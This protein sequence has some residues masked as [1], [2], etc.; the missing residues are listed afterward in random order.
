MEEVWKDIIGH[1]NYQISSLGR[2]KVKSRIYINKLGVSKQ[3]KER[4][5]TPKKWGVS[6]DS[7]PYKIEG[8]MLRHF[9]EKLTEYFINSNT[10]DGEIWKDIAGYEGY[11]KVSNLGRV[12]SLP[13]ILGTK[14]IK[15]TKTL[16]TRLGTILKPIRNGDFDKDGAYRVSVILIKDGKSTN[17]LVNRLVAEAF[18]PNPNNLPE[19]NHINRDITNNTVENLEWIS[20]DANKQHALLSRESIVALYK[21]ALK[22]EVSPSDMLLKLISNY[23]S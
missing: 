14:T 7:H 16:S 6:I 8:L 3:Y 15:G 10:K 5:L 11:Y 4:F 20:A 13:R 23:S 17:K 9:P 21:L 19:V 12:M 1:A 22:E 18:I 2:V